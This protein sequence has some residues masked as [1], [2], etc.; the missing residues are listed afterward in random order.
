MAI[1]KLIIENNILFY[2]VFNRLPLTTHNHLHQLLT[3][4]VRYSLPAFQ[5]V[6]ALS[7]LTFTISC[8]LYSIL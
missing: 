8:L 7:Y 3:D 4:L 6:F 1:L 2:V 5:A